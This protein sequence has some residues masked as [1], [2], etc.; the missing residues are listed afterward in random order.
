MVKRVYRQERLTR[1]RFALDF[2]RIV[3][4][5]LIAAAILG[6][7]LFKMSPFPANKSVATVQTSVAVESRV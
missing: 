4:A 2:V 7:A 1:P 5:P 6:F 3:L